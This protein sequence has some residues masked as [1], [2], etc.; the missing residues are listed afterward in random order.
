MDINKISIDWA[1]AELFSAKIVCLFSVIVILSAVAFSHWGKTQTAKAFVI[2]LIVAGIFLIS[3]GIGLYSAN[4]P[5]LE[6]FEKEFNANP[7]EFILKEIQRTTK[8]ER[9]L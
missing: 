1:R 5:R 8:S 9:E 2:P 7:K 3:V 4:K 6:Q